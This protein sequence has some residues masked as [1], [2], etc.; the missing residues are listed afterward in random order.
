MNAFF[1]AA[2]TPT[3]CFALTAFVCDVAE[4]FTVH[5][6]AASFL[7][8][9]CDTGR[10]EK[11]LLSWMRLDRKAVVAV[12]DKPKPT[13]LEGGTTWIANT[14]PPVTATTVNT[15]RSNIIRFT[16]EIRWGDWFE[17]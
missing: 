1:L 8:D 3:D 17:Q 16:N 12:L 11:S 4:P 2:R 13:L 9:G 5:L 15:I 10:E 6:K 7:T 14:S